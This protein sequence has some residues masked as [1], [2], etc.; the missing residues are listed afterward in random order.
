LDNAGRLVRQDQAPVED[1]GLPH[2]INGQSPLQG[3]A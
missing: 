3:E 2:T 1:D